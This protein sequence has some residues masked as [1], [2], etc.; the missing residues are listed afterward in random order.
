MIITIFFEGWVLY[1]DSVNIIDN[2]IPGTSYRNKYGV[3]EMGFVAQE[4]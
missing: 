3:P 2:F 1:I 4:V